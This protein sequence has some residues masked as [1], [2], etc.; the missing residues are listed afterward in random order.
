MEGIRSFLITYLDPDNEERVVILATSKDDFV[1]MFNQ[2]VG[3][4]DRYCQEHYEDGP[5]WIKKAE[6]VEIRMPSK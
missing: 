3:D 5:C 6:E 4:F 2:L 1:D